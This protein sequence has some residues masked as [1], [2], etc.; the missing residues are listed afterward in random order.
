MLQK[1]FWR[2]SPALSTIVASRIFSIAAFAVQR[3][4][5]MLLSQSSLR[6]VPQ[7]VKWKNAAGKVAPT[8]A[9]PVDDQTSQQGYRRR[10]LYASVWNS[11]TT[12]QSAR[13]SATEH[14]LEPHEWRTG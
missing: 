10:S 9:E 5:L 2:V 6:S 11:N 8:N 14:P 1:I 13:G 3:Y 7:P 12:P 4:A